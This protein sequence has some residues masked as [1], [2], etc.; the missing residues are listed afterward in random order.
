MALYY[1]YDIQEA[2][3]Q[4]VRARR[5][6]SKALDYLENTVGREIERVDQFI[7]ELASDQV[8]DLSTVDALLK[9]I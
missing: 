6:Y 8:V 5:E 9:R 4:A 1:V 7:E 2:L 3:Q